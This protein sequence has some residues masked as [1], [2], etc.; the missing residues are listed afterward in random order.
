M[1]NDNSKLYL[2]VLQEWLNGEG[3]DFAKHGLNR[4]DIFFMVAWYQNYLSQNT[5]NGITL[6]ILDKLITE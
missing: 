4:N 3:I 2:T 6:T 1:K 5:L